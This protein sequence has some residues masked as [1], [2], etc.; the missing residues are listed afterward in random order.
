LREGIEMEI[1]QFSIYLIQKTE[2]W[3]GK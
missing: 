1:Q 2:F 3:G